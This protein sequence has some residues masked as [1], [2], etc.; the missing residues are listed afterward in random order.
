MILSDWLRDKLWVVMEH[1]LN[2]NASSRLKYRHKCRCH[3]LRKLET[4]AQQAAY[5]Y[6]RWKRIIYPLLSMLFF[7]PGIVLVLFSICWLSL[8]EALYNM[9]MGH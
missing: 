7:I 9:K 2:V 1:P 6:P 3:N 5:K 8:E 4:R